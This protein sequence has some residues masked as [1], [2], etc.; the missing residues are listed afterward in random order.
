MLN[1]FRSEPEAFRF[2][3]IVMAVALAVTAVVV[4]LRLLV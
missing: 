3:T 1:P 2:L 4:V